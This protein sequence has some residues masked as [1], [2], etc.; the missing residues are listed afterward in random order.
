MKALT[1]SLLVSF[2]FALGLNAQSDNFD[3]NS[4][5]TQWFTLEDDASLTLHEQNSR[6]EVLS[7]GPVSNATDALY[8]GT[9]NFRLSTASDFEISVD[10]SFTGY[11]TLG[12]N[13]NNLS[14]VFGVG[15][16]LPDGTD[17]AAIGYTLGNAFGFP[18]FAGSGAYRTDDI[19]STFLPAAP[20]GSGKMV[21]SYDSLNDDLSLGFDGFTPFVLENTVK[22]V[23]AASNLIVSLGARG[24]G[25]TLD[26]GDAYFD[27]FEIV[28][29][30]VVPEPATMTL[31]ITLAAFATTLRRRN[32]A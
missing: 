32:R 17:S 25:I 16:D 28:S 5:D 21:V 13:S 24:N 29:G 18:I 7:T 10:F 30:T 27:N 19:Q 11:N 1:F 23:W 26:S 3:N 12:A 20:S 22:T 9:S 8:L 6:L 14:L 2:T 15:R 4:I 31:F